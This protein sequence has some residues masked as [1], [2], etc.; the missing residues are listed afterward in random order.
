ML[1]RRNIKHAFYQPAEKEMITLVHLHLIHPIMVSRLTSL[2][3]F[4]LFSYI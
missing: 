3:L 4:E 1:P 2:A